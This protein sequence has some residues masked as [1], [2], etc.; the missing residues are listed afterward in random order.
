MH[1]PN[2]ISVNQLYKPT[3]TQGQ[4]DS[5]IDLGSALDMIDKDSI[6][7]NGKEIDENWHEF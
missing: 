4:S 6:F 1:G 3:V 7:N 5:K 2:E